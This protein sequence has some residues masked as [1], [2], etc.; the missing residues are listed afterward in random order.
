MQQ[1]KQSE[2][3]FH[4]VLFKVYDQRSCNEQLYHRFSAITD[5]V[6]FN[7]KETVHLLLL[8]LSRKMMMKPRFA[9]QEVEIEDLLDVVEG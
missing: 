2:H 9:G 7:V 6:L 3:N 4:H 5:D 1:Y 8:R